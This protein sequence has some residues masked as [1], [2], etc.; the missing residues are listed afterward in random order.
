MQ[1]LRVENLIGKFMKSISEKIRDLPDF[2][3]YKVGKNTS[4]EGWHSYE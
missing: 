1:N 4:I 2:S 3:V